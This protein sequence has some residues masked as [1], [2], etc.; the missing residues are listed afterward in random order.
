MNIIEIPLV[1]FRDEALKLRNEKQMDYLVNLVGMDWGDRLGVVYQFE[2]TVTGEQIAV[3][4]S[5]TDRERPELPT[6]CDIWKA[7]NFKER[8]VY[9]YFGIRFI[10]HPDMRR[11]V[12]A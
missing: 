3:R 1:Q 5:T 9:D 2:S 10:N 7:A 6:V 11:F 12:P 8:E 4:T